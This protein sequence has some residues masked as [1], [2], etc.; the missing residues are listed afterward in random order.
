MVAI[1]YT[2][3]RL[4]S[5]PLQAGNTSLLGEEDEEDAVDPSLPSV[6]QQG[7]VPQEH[8]AGMG[9]AFLAKLLPTTA[10]LEGLLSEIK[11]VLS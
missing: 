11:Y 2:H 1:T 4:H 7:L 3:T 8:I 9:A 10:H 6:K 5:Q